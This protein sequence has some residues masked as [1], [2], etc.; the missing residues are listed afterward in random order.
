[1]MYRPQDLR[2]LFTQLTEPEL[3][4]CTEAINDIAA[5]AQKHGFA[6]AAIYDNN[7]DKCVVFG[8]A[9]EDPNGCTL[10]VSV[11]EV[12][13]IDMPTSALVEEKP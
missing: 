4:K 5:A 8:P 1:M 6:L 7:T 3:Q 9:K 11:P 2:E 10:V 13:V 12:E